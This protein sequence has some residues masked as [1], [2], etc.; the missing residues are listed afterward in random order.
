MHQTRLETEQLPVRTCPAAKIHSA[1]CFFVNAAG[2]EALTFLRDQ[3]K[4]RRRV[5]LFAF[6]KASG[7]SNTLSFTPNN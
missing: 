7:R 5:G 3:V 1:G 2:N 6:T 4:F